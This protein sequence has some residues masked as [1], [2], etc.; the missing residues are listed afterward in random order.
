ML[1]LQKNVFKY[2]GGNLKFT[3]RFILNNLVLNKKNT[4]KVP[5]IFVIRDPD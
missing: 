3:V 4:S 5:V 2:A 1:Y